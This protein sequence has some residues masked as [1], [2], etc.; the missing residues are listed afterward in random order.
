MFP[1]TESKLNSN[2]EMERK[3]KKGKKSLRENER[4]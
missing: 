4:E 2:S 1:S 3:E